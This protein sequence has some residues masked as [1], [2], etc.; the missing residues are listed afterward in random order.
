MNSTLSLWYGPNATH[1]P[2]IIVVYVPVV[3]LV[4]LASAVR[5]CA[6]V[7]TKAKL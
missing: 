2:V 6:R 4:I 5:I 1:L 7:V 3:F